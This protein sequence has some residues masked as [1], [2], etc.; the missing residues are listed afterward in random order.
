[1]L[2]AVVS[3]THRIQ[4]YIDKALEVIKDADVLIHL[5][6]NADDV[7]IFKENFKGDIFAVVGN[8]DYTNEYPEER[9]VKIE[10]KRIFLTHGHRYNVKMGLNSL[11]YKSKELDVDVALYGHTHQ[12]LIIK[13]DRL[14]IM[15]PGSVSLPRGNGRFVG[16]LEIEEGEEIKAYL[17]EL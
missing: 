2:V 8:C 4:S 16:F 11:Y 14:I 9:I 15:N 12:E 17:K 1:M 5:G 13:E 7:S 3:D 6:D 10:D